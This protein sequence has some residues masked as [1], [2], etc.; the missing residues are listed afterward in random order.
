[1]AASYFFFAIKHIWG[2]TYRHV[3]LAAIYLL[4]SIVHIGVWIRLLLRITIIMQC[5]SNLLN[6]LQLTR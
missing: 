6:V 2:L 1:M 4:T 3:L 5:V